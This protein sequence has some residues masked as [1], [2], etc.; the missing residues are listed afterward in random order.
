M[1]SGLIDNSPLTLSNTTYFHQNQITAKVDH[2]FSDKNHLSGHFNWTERPRM[3]LDSGGLWDPKEGSTGGG[4]L[5]NS[6]LQDVTSRR[7]AVNDSHAFTPTLLNVAS[8]TYGRY[9]NP[10]EPFDN[11]QDWPTQLGV[12]TGA[13]NFPTIGFGSAVNGIS[14]TGLGNQWGGFYVGN[15]FIWNDTLSWVKG[16]HTLKFGGEFRA[17]QLNSHNAVPR[18]GFN[19][20][21]DQTGLPQENFAANKTGFGFASFLLGAAASG[22]RG[23]PNDLYGRRKIGSLFAQDDWKLSPKL[24]LSL[25]LRWEATGPWHERYGRWS[26]FD[27]T[28]AS[29]SYGIP[30]TIVFLNSGSQTFEAQRDWK[31]FA[32]HVGLAYQVNHRVVL[33]GSYGIYASS[34]ESVGAHRFPGNTGGIGSAL[35][36]AVVSTDSR[37]ALT[38]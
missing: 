12:G 21:P 11:S 29:T 2:N 22:S 10:S 31:Q 9:R 3:L 13:K 15:S 8:F 26:T 33:R 35:I 30:G 7:V 32:P 27:T 37:L 16:K 24:T 25:D 1:R 34:G 14:T 18:L 5:A 36:S 28:A 19:F 38:C 23:V 4:P 6:R 17:L 20:S